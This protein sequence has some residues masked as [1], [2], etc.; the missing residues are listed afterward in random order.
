CSHSVT[1]QMSRHWP[2]LLFSL[3]CGH[4]DINL[5][6]TPKALVGRRLWESAFYRGR[7]EE[8]NRCWRINYAGEFHL[9]VLPAKPDQIQLSPTAL[10]V[11][12]KALSTWKETNP[13]GYAK[14]FAYEKAKSLYEAVAGPIRADVEPA[15]APTT[16][17][18]KT[19]LQLAVQLLK[20]HRDLKFE[21]HNDAPI[22]IIITTLAGHA[23]QG[24]QSV[25]ETIKH[26]LTHMPLFIQRDQ[27]GRP[28]VLNPTNECE[29]FCDKWHAEPNKERAFHRWIAQAQ[30]DLIDVA[31]S[32][33]STITEPLA[34]FVGIAY[35]N[36]ALRQY[37]EILHAARG[38]SLTM[39]PQTGLLNVAPLVVAKNITGTTQ[40]ILRR[41]QSVVVH[42]EVLR[43]CFRLRCKRKNFGCCSA[44]HAFASPTPAPALFG[45]VIYNRLR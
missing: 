16:P 34:R 44:T 33:L 32:A 10:L 38:K 45:W 14:W 36:R 43:I 22:S 35:A 18:N 15:P 20:R 5:R 37:G 19:P 28:Y 13:K 25:Y 17:R 9:D 41:T 26:L 23:Y 6:P 24:Q 8:K 39:Q 29:N 30:K 4:I 2:T 11:P 27:L 31:A 40:H 42:G 3:A 12:D 1:V 21:G 7:L